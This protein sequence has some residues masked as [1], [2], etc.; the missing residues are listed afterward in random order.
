[1]NFDLLNTIFGKPLI[2]KFSSITY[3]Q[4]TKPFSFKFYKHILTYA[5]LLRRIST[6]NRAL[7]HLEFRDD[8]RVRCSQPKCVYL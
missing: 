4:S 5:S 3:V 2:N 6:E 7:E 1:M 8:I